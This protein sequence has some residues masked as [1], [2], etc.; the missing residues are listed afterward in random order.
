LAAAKDPAKPR[1][2]ADVRASSLKKYD[3]SVGP[4]S[5]IVD[6][7]LGVTTGN[8][9]IDYSIGV[10]GMPIGRCIELFGPPSSGKTT[11]A[12]QSAA[13]L[14]KIIRSGGDSTRGIG[15]D[16]AIVYMDY[17]QA[18]DPSYAR[19]LGLDVD[20]ESFLFAQP[21]S[22]EQGANVARDYISTGKVRMF[23]WDSVAAMTPQAALEAETGKASVALQ[24]RGMSDFLKVWVPLLKEHQTTSVFVNHIM[25]V[26]DMG[27]G[28]RPG[29]PA[30]TSTPGGRALKFY[31]SVRVEYQQVQNIKGKVLDPLSNTEIDQVVA[32]NVRV[33]VIKNKVA[34]PFKQC[35]VRVRYGRGFD[36]F[37]TALQILI[38]HKQIVYSSGYFYFEK[39]PALVHPDMSVQASGNKRPYVQ[40]EASLFEFADEHEAWRDLVIA[41]AA[42][43]IAADPLAAPAALVSEAE[44]VEDPEQE[45]SP[46]EGLVSDEDIFGLESV[47]A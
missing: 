2:L 31:A 10:G 27:G 11:T 14:Q 5:Q 41:A 3:L 23:I 29:M 38:A 36:N 16:D 8:L 15:P 39:V 34:A 45:V 40:G 47:D 19:A 1:T 30:R 33:R 32:T 25:E 4:L 9:G 26:L 42:E 13:E 43:V 35:I 18:M 21:D 6:D 17:E 7:V 46:D 20:H 22:L 24:A 28:R 12:L 37:W 44:R